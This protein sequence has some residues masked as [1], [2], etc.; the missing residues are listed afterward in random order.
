MNDVREK[1][2]NGLTAEAFATSGNTESG[3]KAGALAADQAAIEVATVTNSLPRKISGGFSGVAD[4]LDRRSRDWGMMVRLL[5]QQRLHLETSEKERDRLY[6]DLESILPGVRASGKSLE[7]AVGT[8]KSGDVS[9]N[10]SALFVDNLRALDQL[11]NVAKA[12]TA[13]LLWTRSSWEQYA[14]SVIGAE[15]MRS[16]IKP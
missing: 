4:E 5:E 7:K 6:A 8:T 14:R 12:L 10:L 3:P 9:G 13:N 11:E 16:E 2:W 1:N 15:K